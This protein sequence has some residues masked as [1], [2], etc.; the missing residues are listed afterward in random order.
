[1]KQVLNI[2]RARDIEGSQGKRTAW[3][4]VG[5]LLI[6]GERISLRL[7]AIPAGAWDGWLRAF[8]RDDER[9]QVNGGQPS[10]RGGGAFA[11]L[12]DDIPF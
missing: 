7:D 6:D 11:D 10:P 8:P 4:R 2:V 3:D 9:R 12:D 1:M 5:V